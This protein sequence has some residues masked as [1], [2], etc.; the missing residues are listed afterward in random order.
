MWNEHFWETES[1]FFSILKN[2]NENSERARGFRL[3]SSII[4][5]KNESVTDYLTQLGTWFSLLSRKLGAYKE[6][7]I[8]R[9]RENVTICD[10]I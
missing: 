4:D 6:S 10:R 8:K 3:S 5:K 2:W 1:I 7:C 9:E